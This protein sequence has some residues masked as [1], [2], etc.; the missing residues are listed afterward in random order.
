M[1]AKKH[2]N[3]LW[4]KRKSNFFIAREEFAIIYRFATKQQAIVTSCTGG[5]CTPITLDFE[6]WNLALI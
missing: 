2:G 6:Q 3:F 4:L 5:V 1:A